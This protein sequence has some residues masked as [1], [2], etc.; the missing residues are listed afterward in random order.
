MSEAALELALAA[1][2]ALAVVGI[3]VWVGMRSSRR[4]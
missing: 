3:V 2:F 4:G 1:G